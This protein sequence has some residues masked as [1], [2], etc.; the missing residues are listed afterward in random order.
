MFRI[1][2]FIGLILLSLNGFSQQ[3]KKESHE[4]QG[5]EV[6]AERIFVKEDAG[7]K[8]TQVDS[9]TLLEKINV[10][11]SDL[12]SEN[13]PIFIKNHGRG[14]LATASFRGTA[15]SHTQVTWNGMNINSPMTGMVD[16]SQIPVYL[17]DEM[18]L[19]HG[20]SSIADNSGGLGGSIN[21]KNTV[22]WNDTLSV[23]YL[24]GI[25]SYC[26]FNEFLQFGIGNKKI[27]SKTR[28]YHNYSKNDFTFINHG[29]VYFNPETGTYENPLDTND[30]AAFKSC[31]VLQEIYF[32]PQENHVLSAKYWG[33]YS[34]RSLPRA[35]SYEGP[36]NSNLNNQIDMDHKALIDWTFY[37]H[38]AKLTVQSGYAYKNLNY[39]LKNNISGIGLIPAVYSESRQNSFNNKAVCQ[40]NISES[41]SLEGQIS[42]D[43]YDVSSHDS[44]QKTGYDKT[45]LELSAFLGIRKSFWN[46][47]NLNLMLR[48]DRVDDQWSPFVPFFGFDFKL[49]KKQPFILKGN[50]ARNFHQPSLNDLYWQP[51]GNPDLLPEKGYSTELGLEYSWR[52]SFLNIASE[53]T[54]Y[55]SD[56]NHWIIWIPSFKGYWEP[57]N[58][59][60][61]LSQ[62]LEINLTL[63]GKLGNFAYKVAGNYAYTSSKNYGDPLV[64]GDE[65]YGKQL[66]YIPLHSGNCL[67]NVSYKGFFITYQFNGYSERFTTSSND[68]TRR[69]W[70]YPYFMNDLFFGKNFKIKNV[71][72]SAELKIYNLFNETYHSILYRPMPKRNFMLQLMVRF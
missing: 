3:E 61:V 68:V 44:V 27:Q 71:H 49:L 13:T 51:G 67:L 35:T 72:L 20:T 39:T 22:N 7:M 40:Y 63:D 53:I 28:I 18:N 15:A 8:R 30:Q 23:K 54:V 6:V 65:S 69:D 55:Q 21:I 37:A 16:F 5:V 12:L 70:L 34:D 4:L 9:I 11:L 25:G 17:I 47:L 66:V 62:G 24:Q 41:W 43:Y 31:G 59:Q 2:L 48:Q 1:L 50:I 26:T 32:R 52:K 38:K 64:W 10:N 46:R 19:K 60:R 14:A 56:I 45:R 29:I 36:D 42:A 58:I 57:R 33:Q